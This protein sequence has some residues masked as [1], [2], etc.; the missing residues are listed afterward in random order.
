MDLAVV[1]K[2]DLLNRSASRSVCAK[3]VNPVKKK[4][5]EN[6]MPLFLLFIVVKIKKKL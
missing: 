4:H 3:Q 2:V 1:P 6:S 5:A